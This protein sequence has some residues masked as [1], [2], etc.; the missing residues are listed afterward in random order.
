M[1]WC[2]IA[3]ALALTAAPSHAAVRPLAKILSSDLD[4]GPTLALA[5]DTVLFTADNGRTVRLYAIP[6]TG[7]P[8]RLLFK[9][10]GEIAFVVA[11]PQRA[12]VSVLRNGRNVTYVGPPG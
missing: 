11:S 5:G 6:A 2:L 3:V 4:A 12:V 7:G 8:A 1:R 9:A 10:P